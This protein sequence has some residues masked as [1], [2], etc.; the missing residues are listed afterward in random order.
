MRSV[1]VPHNSDA[2]PGLSMFSANIKKEESAG[3]II[4]V[5]NS[6]DDLDK[7]AGGM[8]ISDENRELIRNKFF[9]SQIS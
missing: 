3:D 9:Q 8:E 7:N 5:T 6:L 4:V 2:N 1:H